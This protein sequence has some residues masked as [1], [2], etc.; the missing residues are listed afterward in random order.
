MRQYKNYT[1]EQMIEA[2]T[3]SQSC[4]ETL[5]KIGLMAAGGNYLTVGEYIKRYN[6]DISH[7]TGSAWSKDR[8]L[9]HIGQYKRIGQ[10]KK[11][12]I[13][14]RG[15]QCEKCTNSKWQDKLIPLELHHKD[16][17]RTNNSEE[18]LQLLCRNCHAITDNW[19]NK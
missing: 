10:S 5:K 14:K 8:Q 7:W 4:A 6:L 9:K 17:D 19:R 1:D 13:Q 16:G 2:I 12:I 11:W 3:S 18:N 15:H